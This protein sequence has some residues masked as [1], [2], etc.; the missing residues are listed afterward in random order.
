MLEPLTWKP[1]PAEVNQL[2]EEEEEEE[3]GGGGGRG[4]NGRLMSGRKSRFWLPS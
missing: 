1:I 4:V 3:G 2:W